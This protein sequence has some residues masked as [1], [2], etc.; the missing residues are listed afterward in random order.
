MAVMMTP[1]HFTQLQA[2]FQEAGF[3]HVTPWGP[4]GLEARTPTVRAVSSAGDQLFA[5]VSLAPDGALR[6]DYLWLGA[7]PYE[8]I[9][10]A[11]PVKEVRQTPLVTRREAPEPGLYRIEVKP[12]GDPERAYS[13]VQVTTSLADPGQLPAVLDVLNHLGTGYNGP[14]GRS[15]HSADGADPYYLT[16]LAM[17]ATFREVVDGEDR[18]FTA[19][20]TT[21]VQQA[22][23]QKRARIMQIDLAGRTHRYEVLSDPRGVFVDLPTTEGGR[24]QEWIWEFPIT[25]RTW[26]E[27]NP[28][29][30]LVHYELRQLTEPVEVEAG[31]FERCIRLSSSSLN[32][33]AAHTYAPLAG[34]IKSEFRYDGTEGKR[35]LWDIEKDYSWLKGGCHAAAGQPDDQA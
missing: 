6:Y 34:L 30:G 27:E 15:K 19:Y 29:A 26:T 21:H 2:A 10:S 13:H 16:E 23:E 7:L 18:G 14:Y 20:V 5:S 32:G 31:R 28:E 35:E 22:G 8:S 25:E 12:A 4:A 24:H 33:H 17:V 3:T 9:P 11:R 1:E